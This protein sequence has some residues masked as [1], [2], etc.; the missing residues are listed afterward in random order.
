MTTTTLEYAFECSATTTK[1][2]TNMQGESVEGHDQDEQ[3]SKKHSPR[4]RATN[5]EMKSRTLSY[6]YWWF[7]QVSLQLCLPFFW[8]ENWRELENFLHSSQI[9]LGQHNY[10]RIRIFCGIVCL[11]GG[12]GS[13][14]ESTSTPQ[15]GGLLLSHLQRGSWRR[16]K[17]I[18]LHHRDATSVWDERGFFAGLHT[19]LR[20][21]HPWQSQFFLERFKTGCSGCKGEGSLPFGVAEWRFK[22]DFCLRRCWLSEVFK[23]TTHSVSVNRWERRSR[24]T[25]PGLYQRLLENSL[26]FRSCSWR[27]RRAACVCSIC[28]SKLVSQGVWN[29]VCSPHLST[30]FLSDHNMLSPTWPIFPRFAHQFAQMFGWIWRYVWLRRLS[31]LWSRCFQGSRCLFST[32]ALYESKRCVY[33]FLVIRI[34]TFNSCVAGSLPTCEL[35]KNATDMLKIISRQQDSSLRRSIVVKFQRAHLKQQQNKRGCVVIF[36]VLFLHDT[37]NRWS[38][39]EK[40]ARKIFYEFRWI[41]INGSPHHRLYVR[42]SRQYSQVG[43][44]NGAWR[45][46]PSQRIQV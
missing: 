41:P 24:H 40:T 13:I 20:W 5:D 22:A 7:F 15:I 9:M 43:R 21:G 3:H 14:D 2:M 29:A 42:F 12:F 27:R 17:A 25:S 18:F 38:R 4:S 32:V 35:C 34:F 8:A 11:R 6:S 45:L 26:R 1:T 10:W 36:S 30:H 23:K 28:K 16:Q 33:V 46:Q 44:R 39:R 37:N 19:F 31:L